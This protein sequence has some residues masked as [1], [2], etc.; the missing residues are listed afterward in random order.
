MDLQTVLLHD[1]SDL[2]TLFYP[3]Y[4][5]CSA[6]KLSNQPINVMPPL[7]KHTLVQILSCVKITEG[8]NVPDVLKKEGRILN[9]QAQ[10]EIHYG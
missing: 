2:K 6:E 9:L 4:F 8:E 7:T 3:N 10:E 5:I 1:L